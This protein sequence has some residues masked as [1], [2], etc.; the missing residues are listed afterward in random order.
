MAVGTLLK[1]FVIQQA[2]GMVLRAIG[3]TYPTVDDSYKLKISSKS[4]GKER[5]EPNVFLLQDSVNM[6]VGSNWEN[7]IPTGSGTLAGVLQV[8]LQ[9]GAKKALAFT[10]TSRRIWVSSDPVS[11]TIPLIVISDNYEHRDDVMAKV[12]YLQEL[13]LPEETVIG[14]LLTPPGPSPF[15]RSATSQTGEGAFDRGED[16]T[17]QVGEYLWFRNVIIKSVAVS[18]KNRMSQVAKKPTVAKIDL[19]FETYQMLTKYDLK[20]VYRSEVIDTRQ[21]LIDLFAEKGE[22]WMR[23]YMGDAAYEAWA[24]MVTLPQLR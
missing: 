12:H 14:G 11:M 3:S 13:T 8:G 21:T 23:K 1:G 2:K 15:K 22:A 16:I 10:T 19:T 9:A 4:P 18:F 24:K 6:V 20:N 5:G 7:Y 17:I